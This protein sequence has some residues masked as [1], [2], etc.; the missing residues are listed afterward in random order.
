MDDLIVDHRIV[1]LI[2]NESSSRAYFQTSTFVYKFRVDGQECNRTDISMQC[3]NDKY[4]G[5]EERTG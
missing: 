1:P 5:H 3:I 4:N 2:V